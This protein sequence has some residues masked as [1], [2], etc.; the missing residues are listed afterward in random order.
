[1][2][3]DAMQHRAL[4]YDKAGDQHYDLISALHKSVRGSDPDG[5]LYWLARM[6]EAGEDPLYIARRVVRMASEDIG[7]ADPQALGVCVAAQQAVHFVGLPEGVLALA[8]AVV[9]LAT[10]PKSNSLEV[11]YGRVMED[12]QRSANDPV[13]LWLRNAPTRLMKNLDYGKEYKYAHDYYKDIPIDDPDRPPSVQLQEYLPESLKG[14][15]YYEPGMQGK[16]ANI[17]KWLEKR[18]A[19]E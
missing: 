14:R 16:E 8:Q 7:M 11:A 17:K 2:V 3:E 4:L 9:Y 10:A 12:L 13:P 1:M 18:R 6:L 15:H 5:S 19:D